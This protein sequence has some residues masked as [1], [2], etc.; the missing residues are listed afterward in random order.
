M[1]VPAGPQATLHHPALY[2]RGAGAAARAQWEGPG[3]TH[4][5][6]VL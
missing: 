5:G 1:Q 4:G 6:Q 2:R 3:Q